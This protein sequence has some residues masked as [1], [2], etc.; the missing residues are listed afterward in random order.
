MCIC[1]FPWFPIQPVCFFF[2]IIQHNPQMIV[3]ITVNITNI[4]AK[5]NSTIS[6]ANNSVTVTKR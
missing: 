6:C 2:F 4:A 5:H 3:G 1:I